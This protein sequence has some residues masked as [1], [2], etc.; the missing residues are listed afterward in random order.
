MREFFFYTSLR[1]LLFLATFAVVSAIWIL[2]T[3]HLNWFWALILSFLLSGVA[4][5]V[6]LNSPRRALAQR[7]EARA[8]ATM[9]RMRSK[10]DDD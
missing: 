8:S 2:A 10:E 4:S 1:V 7:V 9:E 6:V 5:Y 3:G